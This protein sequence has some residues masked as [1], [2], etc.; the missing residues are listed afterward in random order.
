MSHISKCSLA[1]WGQWLYNGTVQVWTI[2]LIPGSSAE[3][4]CFRRLFGLSER[5]YWFIVAILT[6]CWAGWGHTWPYLPLEG[7]GWG[8]KP[9][10]SRQSSC[11]EW[12]EIRLGLQWLGWQ[13]LTPF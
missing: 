13:E 5:E 6:Q 7:R 2:S 10:A 12:S 9:W 8:Y 1:K 11:V 3:Q 4:P